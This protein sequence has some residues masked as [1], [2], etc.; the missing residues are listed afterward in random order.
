MKFSMELARSCCRPKPC[1]SLRSILRSYIDLW[2]KYDIGMKQHV[3]NR[4]LCKAVRGKGVCSDSNQT[5]QLL[6]MA[7]RKCLE[8]MSDMILDRL[9]LHDSSGINAAACSCCVRALAQMWQREAGSINV[10]VSQAKGQKPVAVWIL[11]CE[12]GSANALHIVFS[13]DQLQKWGI[14]VAA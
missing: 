9:Q 5:A 7:A 10:G 3:P 12:C 14:R 6:Q 1:P 11:W 4:I 13:W 8:S 2:V